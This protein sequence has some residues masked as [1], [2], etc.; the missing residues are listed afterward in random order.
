MDRLCVLAQVGQISELTWG[1]IF[2]LILEVKPTAL[3]SR[4]N[5]LQLKNHCFRKSHLF[6]TDSSGALS[7][8]LELNLKK[9]K[10]KV[11]T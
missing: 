1:K 2:Q 9:K 4:T 7:E 11:C 6:G 3:W 5:H 8:Y 10:M